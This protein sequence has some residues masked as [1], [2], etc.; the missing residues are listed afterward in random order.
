MF[1][2][3]EFPIQSNKNR[4]V[5]LLTGFVDTMPWT[6]HMFYLVM[7]CWRCQQ[8]SKKYNTMFSA[9]ICGHTWVSRDWW[10]HFLYASM[11]S[12]SIFKSRLT[13]L[14]W[15]SSMASLHVFWQK[16]QRG[17]VTRCST[18]LSKSA[19]CSLDSIFTEW[20]WPRILCYWSIME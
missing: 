14:F 20:N 19:S 15:G 1:S 11:T 18:W 9:L 12:T 5:W 17:R 3:V 13:S 7:I 4:E 10:I 8:T 2:L 16:N 6:S